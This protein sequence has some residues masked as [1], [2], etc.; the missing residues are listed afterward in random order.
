MTRHHGFALLR[1]AVAKTPAKAWPYV[2]LG[3]ALKDQ[4]RLANAAREYD[5]ALRI[6]PSHLT[7]RAN[8]GLILLEQGRLDEAHTTA[9][10][11]V[12]VRPAY[13]LSCSK[14]ISSTPASI[15]R[16]PVLNNSLLKR[17]FNGTC[18]GMR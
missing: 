15:R 9:S 8:L 16:E 17:R 12:A 14:F 1:H 7:A 6:D 5:A 13:P 10:R 4:G 2:D 3:S 11:G 18:V